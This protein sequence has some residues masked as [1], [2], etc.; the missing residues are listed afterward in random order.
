MFDIFSQKYRE[1]HNQRV[2]EYTSFHNQQI[3]CTYFL[4]ESPE[5]LHMI[6][7]VGLFQTL[8]RLYFGEPDYDKHRRV[9]NDPLFWELVDQDV[10]FEAMQ[11][12]DS[13][14]GEE[15]LFCLN[16]RF[17][18]E[19]ETEGEWEVFDNLCTSYDVP[20]HY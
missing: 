18:E 15:G 7:S 11:T 19:N 4:I 14:W 5:L 20:L 8:V 13:I 10:F 2:E 1:L 17:R 16:R 6:K 9:P 12:L 3:M